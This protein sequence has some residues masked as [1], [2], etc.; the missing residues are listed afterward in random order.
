MHTAPAV[1][2]SATTETKDKLI[3]SPKNI[4]TESICINLEKEILQN[5]LKN[6]GKT[7]ITSLSKDT[8]IETIYNISI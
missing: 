5:I 8:N 2:E 7:T 1:A 3:D 4:K 6:N